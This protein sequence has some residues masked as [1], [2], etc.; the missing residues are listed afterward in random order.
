MLLYS[1][2]PSLVSK[3]YYFMMGEAE[4]ETVS[5]FGQKLCCLFWGWFFFC[6]IEL[7]LLLVLE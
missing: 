3:D 4:L 1:C 6:L 2:H 5:T 7:S